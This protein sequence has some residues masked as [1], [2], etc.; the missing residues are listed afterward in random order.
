MEAKLA[1]VISYLFHPL[2]IPTYTISLFFILDVYFVTRIPVSV[3]VALGTIV[4]LSTFV[5]PLILIFGLKRVGLI[6]DIH[7]HER[8]ERKI[9][10][11]AMV[12][13]YLFTFYLLNKMQ[14]TRQFNV[15]AFGGCLLA[16]VALL[17][18]SWWKISLHMIANGAMLG[19]FLGLSFAGVPISIFYLSILIIL[20]GFVGFARL[21]LNAHNQAQIYTGLITGVT[22]MIGLIYFFA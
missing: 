6:K 11:L 13:F 10:I 19:L 12:I 14:W 7:M 4:F 8:S 1:K 5:M 22:V 15:F 16:I 3:R 18:N 17:I 2:L 9:P 21:K 20:N